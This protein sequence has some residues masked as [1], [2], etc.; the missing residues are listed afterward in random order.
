MQILPNNGNA[1]LSTE[2]SP[3]KPFRSLN[4]D[5][6][7][8]TKEIEITVNSDSTLAADAGYESRCIQCKIIK[9]N[10]NGA[11][12]SRWDNH[13]SRLSTTNSYEGP[14]EAPCV[15]DLGTGGYFVGWRYT[16]NCTQWFSQRSCISI[17]NRRR[18]GAFIVCERVA[19]NGVQ[20]PANSAYNLSSSDACYWTN[21]PTSAPSKVPT[22]SPSKNPTNT[23]TEHNRFRYRFT[24]KSTNTNTNT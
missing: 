24:N 23:P 3:W 21:D 11:A 7:T 19:V 12:D 16:D 18:N 15:I 8:N 2:G 14:L 20:D 17:R 4:L 13:L 1:Y 9:N 22:S 5:D 6:G 10:N